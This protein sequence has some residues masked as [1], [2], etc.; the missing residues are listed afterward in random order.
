MPNNFMRREIGKGI[1]FNRITDKRFKLN[2]IVIN[3][4]SPLSEET[5][6]ENAVASR[7][8][9]QCSSRYPTYSSLN[10]KLSS[11]YAARLCSS[12]YGFGDAQLIS[13]SIDYLDNKYALHNEKID[14]EALNILLG[15]IF[16]PLT[17][18]GGFSEKFTA[19]ERRSLI[20]GIEAELNDKQYYAGIKADEI[21]FKNEPAAIKDAGSVETAKRVTAKSAYN[22][23]QR[24]LR[25]GRIEIF[26]SGCGDFEDIK[27]KITEQFAKL[28]RGELYPCSTLRSPIKQQP[29]FASEKMEIQ[30]SKMVMAFKTDMEDV[31]AF[32]L[33]NEIYGGSPGSKLFA[34]V[35][36]K[37][38]ICYSCWSG[39]SKIKGTLKAFCGTEK[40][41]V[42]KAKEEMIR[43]LTLMQEGDFSQE[44]VDSAKMCCSNSLRAY[45]D[46]AAAIA[47][48]YFLRIYCDDIISPE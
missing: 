12:A 31:S 7:I 11:L 6:A 26:C 8:I 4:L 23:Y 15:C 10:S 33:L 39:F 16:E 48:W 40:D 37:M 28:D 43:Q 35:R 27:K 29:E 38:S 46:S 22:A 2:T 14:E 47:V 45:N 24:L 19:L 17:E 18:N 25:H 9:S 1:F 30:Q 42:E 3:F 21:I 41:N 13:F 44:D 34:N 5:A 20:E 36:E 32:T